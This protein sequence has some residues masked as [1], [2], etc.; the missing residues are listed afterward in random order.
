MQKCLTLRDHVLNH[1]WQKAY[2]L[3]VSFLPVGERAKYSQY[4]PPKDA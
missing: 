2:I 3:A 4:V 1:K